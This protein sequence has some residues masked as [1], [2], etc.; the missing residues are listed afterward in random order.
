MVTIELSLLIGAV[1]NKNTT[2]RHKLMTVAT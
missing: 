1:E 2:T